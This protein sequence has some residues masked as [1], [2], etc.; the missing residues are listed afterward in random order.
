MKLKVNN[1]QKEFD[2]EL[3]V[4]DL[5]RH[6]EIH[7]RRVAITINDNIIKRDEREAKI[8]KDGDTVDIIEMVGGG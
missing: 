7:H 6:L 5:L 8:L 4:N 3:S 2:R 1:I